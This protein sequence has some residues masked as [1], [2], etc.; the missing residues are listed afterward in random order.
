M[1]I[2]MP[3][4]R[5]SSALKVI[6]TLRHVSPDGRH[7][8]SSPC[9]IAELYQRRTAGESIGA[10]CAGEGNWFMMVDFNYNIPEGGAAD[11]KGDAGLAAFP[12]ETQKP[13]RPSRANAPAARSPPEATLNVVSRRAMHVRD[14]LHAGNSYQ[15][16][17]SWILLSGRSFKVGN[18]K[19]AC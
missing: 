5:K 8:R 19:C 18:V 6:I 7:L 14:P 3:E 12:V 4:P 13:I 9:P 17:K 10:S 2:Q 15:E 11:K 16:P 1:A